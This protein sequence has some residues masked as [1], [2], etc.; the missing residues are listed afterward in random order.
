ME[1]MWWVE[2]NVCWICS[3]RMTRY[4]Y[5]CE[6]IDCDRDGPHKHYYYRCSNCPKNREDTFIALGKRDPLG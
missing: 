4:E 5:T 6:E 3:Y 1:G 2:E